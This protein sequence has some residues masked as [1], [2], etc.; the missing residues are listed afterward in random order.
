MNFKRP[1]KYIL[2]IIVLAQFSCTS[3]WFAGNAV[4][5][6]LVRTF[7]LDSNVAGDL[8]SSVQ[9]GFI[10]GTLVF[11]FFAIADRFSPSKVFMVCALLGASVNFGVIW[12]GHSLVSILVLRFLTGFF[13][14]GIYPIGMKIAADYYDKDLA[15]SLGFLVGALVLGTAFP[16]ALK[17]LIEAGSFEDLNWSYVLIS[18]SALAT[19]G[20]ISIGVFVPDG[21]YRKKAE[22]TKSSGSP[23]SSSGFG[24]GTFKTVFAERS[25]RAAAMGYFGH[26]W[27]LYAFWT[28][29]PLLLTYWYM[30]HPMQHFDYAGKIQDG[31]IAMYSFLI[32]GIGALA[33]VVG[34]YLA[35]RFGARRIAGWALGLSGL[36]CVLLPLVFS[37]GPGYDWV[38]IGFL[39]IWGMVVIADSPL[40]SS[41]VAQN[42]PIALKGTALTLVNCIGFSITIVSIQ[43]LGMLIKWFE[44][45]AFGLDAQMT[46]FMLLAIGPLIGLWSLVRFGRLKSN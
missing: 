45:S 15:K 2:W 19:L 34:G 10:F 11:A 35:Q 46:T 27:E 32:I 9:F 43:L 25:F 36:C 7:S 6:D 26:M 22:L 29:V 38:F 12:E 24:W 3:L 31:V 17:S 44:N 8:T 37:F 33:C 1:P 23:S 21:P 16:H 41:L 13:L 20:G 39:M 5:P 18:T 14:A 42:A 40:F 30:K 4:M 28:F